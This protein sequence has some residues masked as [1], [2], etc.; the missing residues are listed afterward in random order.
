VVLPH[1][2]DWF[3]R[4]TTVASDW[5]VEDLLRA[6]GSQRVSVVLPALDEAETVGAIVRTVRLELVEVGL[7][8]EILV[9]D[10]GSA[11]ATGAIASA[12]GAKV[13]HRDEVLPEVPSVAGKGE[14]LWRSLAATS[15]DIVVFVDADLTS[16]TSAYV[17]GLLGPLLTDPG[18]AFV[19][20]TYDRPLHEGGVVHPAGG[21]R[22][23]ELLA[24][25]LLNMYWPELAGFVQPLAGEYSARRELLEALP[26]ACGYGVELALLI[27]TLSAVGLDAMAQVD[28]GER[29]HRHHG[30]QRLGR[31]AGEILAVA[32]ARRDQGTPAS[33][34]TLT[35]FE[36]A[37]GV[38][39]AV[40]HDVSTVELPPM[41]SIASY[42]ARSSGS[43]S[44]E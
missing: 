43:P 19:K 23:T 44:R 32:M 35:Q 4:R 6:K 38:Y 20:A 21:G 9:V 8:E 14:S 22:V 15:G 34:Q 13:V 1:V 10:S 27:D 42:A 17:S 11:D 26:F 25:P 5:P 7:V 40:T 28:V 39:Q 3:R 2:D 37:H 16:F 31:M 36:R 18:T 41:R 33:P 12:E 29:R 30:D 24:R